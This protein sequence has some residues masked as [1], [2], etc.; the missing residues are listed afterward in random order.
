MNNFY[1]PYFEEKC[2]ASFSSA[3]INFSQLFEKKVEVNLANRGR[4]MTVSIGMTTIMKNIEKATGIRCPKVSIIRTIRN[5]V[6]L[7]DVSM[8]NGFFW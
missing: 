5:T 7:G 4:G 6:L 2:S 3:T 1:L 8:I